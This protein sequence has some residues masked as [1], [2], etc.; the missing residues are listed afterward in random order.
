M[1]PS[2]R[3]GDSAEREVQ[4]ILRDLLGVPTAR[5]ALGAGRTDD[6]GDIHGLPDTC[7]QV[8]ARADLAEA[9]RTKLPE[10]VAQQNRAG[11]LFGALFARRRGG[12]YVV[13]MTVDQ[14]ATLWREAQPLEPPDARAVEKA[15]TA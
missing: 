15:L 14:F 13:C 3:K 8:T 6:I 2:K 1:H 7:I 12:T 10:T 5:R 11:A 9:I 4:A